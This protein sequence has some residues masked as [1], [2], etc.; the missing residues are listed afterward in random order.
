MEYAA[1][2]SRFRS[3][4]PPPICDCSQ[5]TV[6]AVQ[7]TSTFRR[8]T[9]TVSTSHELSKENR[10]PSIA[11]NQLSNTRTFASTLNVSV[12]PCRTSPAYTT[13]QTTLP[14]RMK[15]R[16]LALCSTCRTT[17]PPCTKC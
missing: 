5:V 14:P 8:K 13:Y 17:L 1:A 2:D 11:V 4:S 7:R 10:I 15:F 9:V 3:S 16:T 12:A 6:V